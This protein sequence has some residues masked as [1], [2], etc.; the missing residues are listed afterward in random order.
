[1]LL[2]VLTDFRSLKIGDKAHVPIHIHKQKRKLTTII[3][4]IIIKAFGQ[5]QLLRIKR[6]LQIYF[7]KIT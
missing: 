4:I 5:M 7:S 2:K 1:M 3:I 6:Q